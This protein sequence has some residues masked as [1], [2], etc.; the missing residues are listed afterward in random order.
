MYAEDQLLALS[1]VQHFAYCPRQWAL[2]HV[3]QAWV[4]NVH[5]I[6][7]NHQHERCH[8]E[9]IREHRGNVITVRGLRV[10]SYELGLTGI[11]DVVE[12]HQDY[13]G[14]SLNGERGN[15]APM[16]VEY[17]KG[18]SKPG[19][20]DRLQVCAQAMAL[21][22]MFCCHIERGFL[23]YGVKKRREEVVFTSELR[24]QLCEVSKRMHA[25]FQRG[26]TPKAKRRPGCRAC[27]LLSLCM[28]ELSS[29]PLVS[30]YLNA[31]LCR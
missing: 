25:T 12:F 24:N 22:E 7:G 17:K 5:T 23:F 20:E 9:G 13:S 30:D 15:W 6:E 16:P 19:N 18:A 31:M 27:S 3:E 29:M 1:G 14:A 8:D 4:D 21:E 11:C 10:V 26:S 28:P 2:I